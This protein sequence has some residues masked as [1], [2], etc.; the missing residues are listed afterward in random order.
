MELNKKKEIFMA[1]KALLFFIPYT[2]F[3]RWFEIILGILG[4]YSVSLILYPL[5]RLLL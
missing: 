2:I 4:W 3:P 5:I 1:V